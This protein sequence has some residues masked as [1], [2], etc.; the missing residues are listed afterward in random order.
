[1]GKEPK[2]L[3]RG[4]K[5]WKISGKIISIV[6]LVT[7]LTSLT[8]VAVNFV[9]NQS[10]TTKSA[11][12]EQLVLGDEVIL[13][14][15][16]QVF[17]SLKV[18]ETLAMTTSLVDAVK[19]A[20]LERA[21]YTD[22]D[23]SSLDQAWIDDEPSI[24]AQVA[25]VA[26]NELS[27]YLKSFIAKNL[28][29]V[30]VFV[31]DIRGLNVAMTDRTSDFWQG[32]EGWWK[33]TFADGKGTPFIAAVEYDESSKAYAMNIG[34][35][36]Y[37]PQTNKAIGVLRG[38]LDVSLLI[39]T[40]GNVRIGET[41][42]AT[43]IDADGNILYDQNPDLIMQPAPEN[44]LNL[45]ASG[46]SGWTKTAGLGGQP[47]VVSYSQL[48]GEKAA[49]LPWRIF[50]TR[51]QSEL[52]ETIIRNL[53]F[54]AGAAIIVTLL[55][56]ILAFIVIQAIVKPLKKLTTAFELLSTGDLDLT[57]QDQTY[58]AG[59][60]NQKD[61]I[62]EM[63]KASFSL[64]DYLK[65]M[66][67]AAQ[68]VAQGDLSVKVEA[69]SSADQLGNAFSI[70]TA[71]LGNL[72]SSISENALRVEAASSELAHAADES[73]RATAQ[74]TTTIQQMASG[75]N[76]FASTV[77]HT[78]Q[79][80][81]QMSIA[82]DGVARGAQDQAQ[83]V[84]N[85]TSIAG[86][87]TTT[88]HEI[89]SNA[90]TG[91]Q[92]ASEAAQ[93][94]TSGA[95]TVEETILGMNSI[96]TKVGISVEKVQEM[97]ERSNQ[98]GTIVQTIED[99]SS[100]TNLLAL[101]AAIEAARA[102]EQGK[103]F[104]VVADEVRKLAERSSQA[105]KEISELISGIQVTVAEAVSAMNDGA[106][107][108][109]SGVDK[110]ERSGE[111]LKSILQAVEAVKS[112][113]SS[114]AEAAE[115]INASAGELDDS[116][117]SVSAVVEENT[118]ATEEMS[119]SSSEVTSAMELIASSSEETSASIEEVSASTEEMSAQVQEVTASA[120]ELANL[121]EILRT[122]VARFKLAETDTPEPEQPA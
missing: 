65:Q 93:T 117:S 43:L 85:A 100:Q 42:Y 30:E 101:N 38:T 35:P 3:S 105:T 99:I 120:Q 107:E 86:Q 113:V 20:N 54:S 89:A 108:V 87:I 78:S 73:S 2:R 9:L 88:I 5:N 7:I 104:A 116:M 24:Q 103:G 83:A 47:A 80:V 57:G 37:D 39:D 50:I 91:S 6:I 106:L 45:V 94:A 12:D 31:T 17:T 16:D 60:V 67:Q 114:I 25:A 34:A 98:I 112:Q 18:L 109:E 72:V 121:A 115:R 49:Q 21:E 1:M 84:N 41:G 63:Y 22:A 76:E 95:Q 32:D 68:R 26:N 51:D 79:S 55:G 56:V 59:I 10:Q 61:E 14:A 8:L 66:V 29:E 119:A 4:W 36:I 69:R 46:E 15:S 70:M 97:G 71:D 118:A 75:T 81:E 44:F 52:N 58:L 11:G 23:I 82:I 19:A 53:S 48:T 122:L 33:S 62:G 92:V 96:K 74:I 27:D 28:D 64:L 90:Q 77:S 40:L 13:R 111:A 102:G 110:A